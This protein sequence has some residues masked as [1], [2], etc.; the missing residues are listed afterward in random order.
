MNSR[1]VG[2]LIGVF[3]WVFLRVF[4]RDA[5]R[6]VSGISHLLSL[7]VHALSL[8]VIVGMYVVVRLVMWVLFFSVSISSKETWSVVRTLRVSHST[9]PTH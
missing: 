1:V 8:N 6:S 5:L 7:S 9:T 4:L 3:L 2:V